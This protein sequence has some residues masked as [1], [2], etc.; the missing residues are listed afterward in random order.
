MSE[1]TSGGTTWHKAF[2][3]HHLQ[4]CGTWLV[5]QLAVTSAK[6]HYPLP[7]CAHITVWSVWTFSKH[8]WILMVVNFLHGRI[9]WH[10]SA[11]IFYAICNKKKKKN[12][13]Q[14]AGR[15]YFTAIPPTSMFSIITHLLMGVACGLFIVG[16]SA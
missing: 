13:R 3:F 16:E 10:T 2:S 7:N 8:W 9:Q 4:L 1:F 14:M 11:F 12:Y 5:T 15:C 6:T